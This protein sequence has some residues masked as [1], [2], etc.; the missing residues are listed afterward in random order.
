[1][2]DFRWMLSVLYIAFSTS[3]FSSLNNFLIRNPQFLSIPFFGALCSGGGIG[4]FIPL[5]YIPM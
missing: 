1:M 2:D 5:Q 3:T 4:T